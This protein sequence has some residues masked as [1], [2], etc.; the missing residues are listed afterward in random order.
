MPENFPLISAVAK[1]WF[2]T[3]NTKETLDLS[4]SKWGPVIDESDG[5]FRIK[6]RSYDSIQDGTF[7][8]DRIKL[9][10]DLP[11][12]RLEIAIENLPLPAAFREA[13][14]A[15]RALIRNKRKDGIDYED[16]LKLL[17]TLAAV[18]SFGVPY[19][20]R[21]ELP[22]HNVLEFTPCMVIR[23]LSFS[24]ETLG[25]DELELLNKTDKN[26]LVANWGLPAHHSTLHKM[27]Q[28]VWHK[29]EDLYV[30]EKAR[31]E[32]EIMAE[33]LGEVEIP[34]AGIPVASS[35]NKFQH[36]KIFFLIILAIIIIAIIA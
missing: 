17:Y 31:R 8:A 9:V 20:E 33:L 30:V 6:S 12:K 5:G 29:Y 22:G 14:I 25:F 19:S 10:R 27:H 11:Q 35:E 13:A 32:E 15:L 28:H 36:W 24:Y 16:E 18:Q 4:D 23:N 21:L 26:W 2:D 1:S 7:W 34:K 3:S